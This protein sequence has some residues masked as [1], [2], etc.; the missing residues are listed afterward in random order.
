VISAV[1]CPGNRVRYMLEVSSRFPRR[2]P[3]LGG[4]GCRCLACPH[5]LP[6]TPAR[7]G[8]AAVLFPSSLRH[9]Q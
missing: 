6:R 8:L 1:N 5:S 4:V 2:G 7:R 3:E 9:C